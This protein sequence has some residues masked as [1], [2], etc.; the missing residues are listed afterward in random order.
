M[1]KAKLRELSSVLEKLKLNPQKQM[2]NYLL[3][4]LIFISEISLILIVISFENNNSKNTRE[5][6]CQPP[7]FF[8]SLQ[9]KCYTYTAY[10]NVNTSMKSSILIVLQTPIKVNDF[11]EFEKVF[12]L[13][14]ANERRAYA[15]NK[16]D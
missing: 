14:L 12:F 1:L 13:C 6:K 9:E 8:V 10:H 7:S 15:K 11:T 3:L 16:N 4:I 5:H 2:R